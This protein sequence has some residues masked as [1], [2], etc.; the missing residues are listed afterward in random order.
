M[1]PGSNQREQ[2]PRARQEGGV[3][4]RELTGREEQPVLSSSKQGHTQC[5]QTLENEN[6]D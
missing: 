5:C 6:P 3:G 1:R 4:T 2:Q